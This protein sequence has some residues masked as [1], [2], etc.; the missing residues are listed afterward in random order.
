MNEK[1]A[2]FQESNNK[3]LYFNYLYG[4]KN[5]EVY[6]QCTFSKKYTRS[7]GREYFGLLGLSPVSMGH[8]YQVMFLL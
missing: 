4:H 8:L 7:L 2:G 5:I 1:L 6:L 3:L